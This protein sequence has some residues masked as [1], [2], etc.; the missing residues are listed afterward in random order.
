MIGAAIGDIVGSRFEWHPRKSKEFE[1]FSAR[2]EFTDDTVCTAAVADIVMHDRPPADTLQSWCIRYPGRGY[3]GMFSQWIDQ[4]PPRPYGSFGNG[5]AMR[6]SPVAHLYRDSDLSAALAASDT[7]TRVTHDHREGIKGARATVHAIW[8]AY[9]GE[10]VDVIR[11]RIAEEYGY[12]MNRT[13]DEIRPGYRFNETCQRTVPEAL[14]CAFESDSFEDAIRNAISLG[15]DA[16]TLGA[17]AGPIAEALH[18]IPEAFKRRA[19]DTYLASAED[20]RSTLDELYQ[21]SLAAS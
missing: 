1:F 2:C 8:L 18:G 6:V 16:D 21:G 11:D 10:S 12:D 15:G 7:V 5:A 13:V 14:I 4:D 3:G 17:I 19:I 9:R 20:I